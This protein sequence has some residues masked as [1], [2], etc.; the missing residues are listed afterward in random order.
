MRV[1][2]AVSEIGDAGGLAALVPNWR[3]LWRHAPGAD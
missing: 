2:L 1:E 3:A